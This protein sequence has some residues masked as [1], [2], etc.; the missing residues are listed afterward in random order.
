MSPNQGRLV[1]VTAFGCASLIA[2]G[3]LVPVAA[4]RGDALLILLCVTPSLLLAWWWQEHFE[5]PGLVRRSAL[6]WFHASSTIRSW[7]WICVAGLM[8]A[9]IALAAG[10]ID[11]RIAFAGKAPRLLF[12]VVLSPL[13]PGIVAEWRHRYRAIGARDAERRAR[14]RAVRLAHGRTHAPDESAR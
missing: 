3:S 6:D 13:V 12:F 14:D 4:H 1:F 5:W 9:A 10:W 8:A 7:T 2:A 11:A